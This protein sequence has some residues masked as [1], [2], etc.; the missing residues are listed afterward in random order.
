MTSNYAEESALPALFRS[1]DIGVSSEWRDISYDWSPILT[2]DGVFI[3]SYLRDTYDQQRNLRPFLLTPEGPTK[4]SIQNRLGLK[5]AYAMQGPE[6][7]LCT[8][9]LLHVE[10]GYGSSIDPERPNHTHVA[11]YVVGRLDHPVL[12]WTM[13]ERVLD[14]V[15][16]ALD[17]P[18]PDKEHRA[19]QKRADAALRSLGQAGLLQNCDP[20]D[21][22]YPFGAWPTLLSTLIQDVRWVALFSHLHGVEAIPRY[23][24]K[25]RAWIEYSQRS[26]L[27]LMRKNQAIGA[28]LLAAQQRGPR[29]SS[30][31]DGGAT[32][33]PSSESNSTITAQNP[34]TSSR[35]PVEVSSTGFVT[36][37]SLASHWPSEVSSTG[38]VT[39][40]HR[41]LK[42]NV[43]HARASTQEE[44]LTAD[45]LM[46]SG[47][48]RIYPSTSD[49]MTYGGD[50]TAGSSNLALIEPHL[51]DAELTSTRF[52][53]Y[54]WC[55]VNQ[56]LHQ[57]NERYDAT[58]GEKQA[59]FRQ[60]KRQGIQAG[61]VLAALRAVMTLP[62]GQ[63]P[64]RF[65]DALKMSAF[66]AC[67]QQ[68]LALLPA[69]A[70][71]VAAESTW[72][73]FLE[74]YRRVGQTNHLRDVSASDYHVLYA[75]FA[76][77]P[78]EC[79]E[80][81]NRVEHAAQLPHLSP[82]YM[83]R[84]IVNNQRAAAQQALLP[85]EQRV[86]CG[87][88]SGGPPLVRPLA[89]DQHRLPDD[90][91]HILLRQEGVPLEILSDDMTEEYIRHWI[92]EADRR[93]EEL[94]S[95]PGWLKWGIESGYA[96]SVHP[97]LR[98]RA[99]QPGGTSAGS[100][101]P[102]APKGATSE[103][104]SERESALH[105]FWQAALTILEATLPRNEFETWI[106]PC[107]MVAF[108]PGTTSDEA[109][110]VIIAT[111][112]IF[113]RQELEGQYLPRV[114]AALSVAL[115]CPVQVQPVIGAP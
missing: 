87:R 107:Q 32:L 82:A 104:S 58:A 90:P 28:Q 35:K 3:Y 112:N 113:V 114:E 34:V 19:S 40:S 99:K 60:F 30:S 102:V 100:Y 74:V 46:L 33:P 101:A 110:F 55:A 36:G 22:F 109:T 52:D 61:V 95:R 38:L 81:L 4:K 6:Y 93:Q 23:Q 85:V 42:K 9:G 10:I 43:N 41:S 73:S 20:E 88:A 54:F 49:S 18:S 65:G 66:H 1:G 2:A 97:H 98:P 51:R 59:V 13:L 67:V 70:E 50:R 27:R 89:S 45:Q 76:K 39:P 48:E 63:R 108:E 79:W 69:R 8:V 105:A 86:A 72:P 78:N 53:A 64:L 103:P 44:S 77:Q 62:L 106:K 84:A 12:N 57:T 14:A 11:Y 24:Q 94:Y 26:A 47:R 91:R 75:L 15:M 80:V 68:V 21:L 25:A 56:I 71:A 96:P 37:E 31:S 5:S 83:R 16:L 111:P 17:A 29:G 92:A 7:L 115:G